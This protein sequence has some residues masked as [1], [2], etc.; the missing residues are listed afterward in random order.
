MKS[1][2]ERSCSVITDQ[3]R[4][5]ARILIVD[6]E[7]INVRIVERLLGKAGYRDLRGISNPLH[8][9]QAFREFRPD[10][11]ILDL[12]MPVLD[13]FTILETEE[14]HDGTYLPVLV[15]TGDTNPETRRRALGLG[16]RDFVCKPFDRFELFCRVE[17][18]LEV[19]LLHRKLYNQNKDLENRVRERTLALQEAHF[20]MVRRLGLAAEYRDDETG[21]HISRMSRYAVVVARAMGVPIEQREQLLHAAAL[22]D[23]GKI[24]I[25]DHVLLKKGKLTPEEWEIMKSHAKIGAELMRGGTSELMKMAERVARWHH[26]RWDGKGYPDGLRGE[27]IPIEARI[28]TV[29][30]VFD[31]LTSDRV[32][33][34]A[35]VL[36]EALDTMAQC[37]GHHFDPAVYDAFADSRVEILAIHACHADAVITL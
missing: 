21:L 4:K 14:F 17:N 6:D 8:F 32:Y 3:E 22:H 26:E 35:V 29:C 10:L 30:D 1:G 24:G 23:V 19:R 13:G 28:A 16:A 7:E 25:P 27:Q 37:R 12:N 34:D 2:S 33:R 36:D 18:L 11:V 20:E 31:A 15:L 9:E 5:T